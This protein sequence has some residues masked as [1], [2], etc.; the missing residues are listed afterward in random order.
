MTFDEHFIHFFYGWGLVAH[1]FRTVLFV[2]P[3][4]LT[5]LLSVGFVYIKEQTTIDPQYVFSPENARWRYERDILTSY[6]PLNEHKFWP[7]KSYDLSGYMDVIAAGKEDPTY[8][9]P[10][11]LISEYILELDRINKYIVYNLSV[12]VEH[13]GE[14]FDVHYTDLCMTYDWKCFLNDHITIL[15]PKSHWGSFQGKFAE[16]ASEIIEKEIKI[17][18][19]IGWRGTEPIYFGALVGGVHLTD[20]E[21]HFDYVKA[22]RLTYNTR[23]EVVGNISYIWRK[24]VADYLTDKENP[25][26]EILTFGLTHNESLPEGLQDVA[27]TLTPKFILMSTILFCFCF[28]CSIV[29][30]RHENIIVGID[31]VRSKP[32]LGLA[33]LICP[34]LATASAFGLVLWTGEYYNA[35]VNVSPFIVVCIGIDDA[36]LMNAAWHR[37][38]PDLS[39]AK[40]LAETLSEAAVAISITSITDMLTFGIGCFTTLPGVRLFCLYTFWGITFTYLYQITYFTAVMAFAGEMEDKGMHSLFC[41]Q[42][43]TPGEADNWIT[44]WFCS[45][46][47]CR[48]LD[49]KMTVQDFNKMSSSDLPKKHKL[50]SETASNTDKGFFNA[51]KQFFQSLQSEVDESDHN[52]ESHHGRE[53]L[54]NWFFR[55]VYGP[56]L[57][58]TSSKVSVLLIYLGYL[59]IALFGCAQIEEGLNPRNLVRSEFY[60]TNF[61]I[62][63]D[64]TFWQEGLQMQVVVNNPPDLF[65]FNHRVQFD[66]M[67]SSFENTHYTMSHNATMLWLNAFET[68]LEEDAMFLNISEPTTS[69]EYYARIKE[70]LITTGG[71]RL[72]E[73]DIYWDPEDP[74]KLSAFRFQ[75]GLKNYRTP[76]DHTNSCKLMRHLAEQYPEMN[77]TTFHEYYPFADQYLEL[78]PALFRNCFLAV[79]CMMFVALIMIPHYGAAIAIILSIISIDVGV[80]GYMALW[81]VSLECVSMITVIMSIGFSVDLSAHITYAYV[82]APG[83]S[84]AKAVTALETLGW[85]VFLGAFT[86]I[87]GILVLTLV[88]AYIIQIFFKTIF[89]VIA[90]SLLHGIVFLP[91][92]LTIMLPKASVKHDNTP[93]NE[94]AEQ[95]QYLARKITPKI[96]QMHAAPSAFDDA[97]SIDSKALE[98][99]DLK[100]EK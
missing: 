67:V 84:S 59:F 75:V 79:V 90:S 99:V 30:L 4:V 42:C 69:A 24:K 80:L 16:L 21:G 27:D 19:P 73:K 28:G 54:V 15:Q 64:E 74:S 33:A 23:E 72:W 56:M 14:H 11:M 94:K 63:I 87:V 98:D 7:G 60:L 34:L 68:Q 41:K 8:G 47:V 9:R 65:D 22:V 97:V 66:E 96:M 5:A 36:F 86:T 10:N 38:N 61:Y 62:L 12:P 95:M 26:S 77:I 83:C 89:L 31:W 88:D 71:R 55:E 76:T 17:T 85:P 81:G 52:L 100:S 43:V 39:V 82:K 37:T 32:I 92:L 35:I 44:K 13:N 70:W 20:D 3:F 93:R 51:V 78:K 46:S 91:V 49:R 40:R 53:T 48:H 2:G 45:G 58:K 1:R 29:V 25:P 18:Y 50:E 6:W 57:L